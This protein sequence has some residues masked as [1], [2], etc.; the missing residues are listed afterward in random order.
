[1]PFQ[2][3]EGQ[4]NEPEPERRLKNDMQFLAEFSK[5]ND[6]VDFAGRIIMADKKDT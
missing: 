3:E 2:E 4:E 6:N 5:Q 1:M